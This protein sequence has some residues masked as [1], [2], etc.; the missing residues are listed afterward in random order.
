MMLLYVV[1][2]L[3]FV[4]VVVVVPLFKQS[5]TPGFQAFAVL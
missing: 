2:L 4:V 5:L 1:M 3:A